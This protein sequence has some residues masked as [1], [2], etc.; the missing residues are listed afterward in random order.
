MACRN[1][2]EDN[3]QWDMF[4]WAVYGRSMDDLWTVVGPALS[5]FLLYPLT[6]S[7]FRGLS[8]LCHFSWDDPL[9]V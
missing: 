4:L 6:C 7:A 5:R 2:A 9:R 3:L 8:P 1:D